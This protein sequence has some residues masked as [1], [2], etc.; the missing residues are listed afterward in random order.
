[1]AFNRRGFLGSLVA[2]IAGPFI[3]R[4]RENEPSPS[5]ED[6][7]VLCEEC[8]EVFD[9]VDQYGTPH[10]KNLHPLPP[11]DLTWDSIDKVWRNSDGIPMPDIAPGDQMEY[12]PTFTRDYWGYCITACSGTILPCNDDLPLDLPLT[13]G[14]SCPNSFKYM[15]TI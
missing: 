15:R 8:G 7:D 9:V 10:C 2:C 6:E 11:N 13:D 14:I 5:H 12:M 3:S 1:M 4:K